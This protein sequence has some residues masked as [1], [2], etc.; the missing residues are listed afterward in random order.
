MGKQ[1]VLD[2]QQEMHQRLQ[3]EVEQKHAQES[4]I[5]E[6]KQRLEDSEQHTEGEKLEDDVTV[7]C[8]QVEVETLKQNLV[9]AQEVM[10]RKLA[11]EAEE[12]HKLTEEATELQR[13]VAALEQEKRAL[14][15]RAV[16]E[17]ESA[18]LDP[19]KLAQELSEATARAEAAEEMTKALT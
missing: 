3:A 15:E 12:K 6:M 11:E 14:E 19:A 17:S 10:H 8:L 16:V 18:D 2:T 7:Q 9:D 4:L 1:K 13:T 5:V